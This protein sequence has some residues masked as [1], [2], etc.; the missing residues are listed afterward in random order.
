[1]LNMN[2]SYPVLIS[3][4]FFVINLSKIA[5]HEPLSWLVLIRDISF[6]SSFIKNGNFKVLKNNLKF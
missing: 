2:A 5:I 4:G 3:K 1:M 6:N